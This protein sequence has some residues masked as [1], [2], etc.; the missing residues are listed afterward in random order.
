MK[1]F[2]AWAIIDTLKPVEILEMP[3]QPDGYSILSFAKT[4]KEAQKMF[5]SIY[6]IDNKCKIKKVKINICK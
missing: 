1:T 2:Y 6:L 5:K 3:V 4:K